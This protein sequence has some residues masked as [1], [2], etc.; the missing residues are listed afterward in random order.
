MGQLK[1]NL[2]KGRYGGR[3]R[4]SGRK[5]VHSKGVAHRERE[6]VSHKTPLHINFKY[7]TNIKNKTTLRLLKRAIINSRSH[8][9]RI[10]HY[11]MQSNHI[12]LIVEAVSNEIL[13]RGMRSL[14]ITFAK[15]LKLGKV[16]TERYH[17]HVLKTLKET[18]NTI[19]YVLFNQQKHEKGTYS[20]M[21]DYSSLMQLKNAL[22]LIK[23][24]SKKNWI[25]I[26]VGRLEVRWL[27]EPMSYLGRN[28]PT[29]KDMGQR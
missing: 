15:G 17:L 27:D 21:D 22:E 11:S 8:G 10:L 23:C 9:L 14:T 1:L 26:E 12:H 13:T 4:G 25:T 20:R 6:K 16:Q 24:F 28:W 18:R 5:R 19:Q 29:S 2:D 7:R 3:R